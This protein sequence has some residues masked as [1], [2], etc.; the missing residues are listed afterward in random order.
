LAP[1]AR[2]GAGFAEAKPANLARPAVTSI[3]GVTGHSLGA[4]GAIE[5]VSVALSYAHRSIPPTMGTTNVDPAFDVDVVLTPRE[6]TPGPAISNSF[7][8]GGH[9]G[10]L[11][12][13]P[14]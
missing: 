4:A 5:A 2:A 11:V 1:R 12:F 8:F 9:N 7:G 14:A 6:W 10:T 13:L 3:K